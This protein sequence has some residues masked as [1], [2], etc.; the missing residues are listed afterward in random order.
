MRLFQRF[1]TLD[2]LFQ[3]AN[4]AP[5][6]A[7]VL[8]LFCKKGS[9]INPTCARGHDIL[10]K[11]FTRA[12]LNYLTL[13][14]VRLQNTRQPAMDRWPLNDTGD[15]TAG[16]TNDGR[17][18]WDQSLDSLLLQTNVNAPVPNL[19]GSLTLQSMPQ[20]QTEE[21]L[22][23]NGTSQGKP[24]DAVKY[25]HRLVSSNTIHQLRRSAT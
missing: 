8:F 15:P 25:S 4:K 3:R 7:A 11:T 6:A 16:L 10:G 23:I 12:A 20:N 21:Q 18:L 5:A 9:A 13:T 22:Q 14:L 17:L 1:V 24:V 2:Q 19:A